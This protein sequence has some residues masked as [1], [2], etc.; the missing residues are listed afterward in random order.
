M[1]KTIRQLLN[2]IGYDI[3]KTNVHDESKAGIIK[4]V[5]V[6]RFQIGMPGNNRQISTYKYRPDANNLLGI[7]SACVTQ[8]YPNQWVVDIGANVGDTIAIIKTAINNPI[9]GI[10]GDPV[11]FKFLSDNT[12]QFNNVTILKEF[13]GEKKQ[14]LRVEMEKTE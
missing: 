11:S 4:K 3:I 2:K 9:I 8:K 10:E 6:G 1:R 7:L 13:L 14:T 5:Q 12:R